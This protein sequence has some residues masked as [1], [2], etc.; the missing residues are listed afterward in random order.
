MKTHIYNLL[1]FLN[2]FTS[3][4]YKNI[5][6]NLSLHGLVPSYL[7]EIIQAY[8]PCCTLRS[9]LEFWQYHDL[10]QNQWAAYHSVLL[11]LLS[12]FFLHLLTTMQCLYDCSDLYLRINFK[13]CIFIVFLI[14]LRI[15]IINIEG[16]NTEN[17]WVHL[18]L[19]SVT[20]SI[21]ECRI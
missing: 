19:L 4:K 13:I 7:S 20:L 3:P 12:D 5:L 6:F 18:I 10:S 2:I 9:S 8:I 11:H 16:V 17:V 1:T 21:T 15:I 14:R